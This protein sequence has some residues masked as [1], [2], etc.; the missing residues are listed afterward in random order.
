MFQ[1]QSNHFVCA[2]M[3]YFAIVFGKVCGNGYNER[4][5]IVINVRKFV[6]INRSQ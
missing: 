1:F 2:Q 3:L 6:G 4:Q 5:G